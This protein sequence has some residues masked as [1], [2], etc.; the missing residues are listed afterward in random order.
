MPT[1][2]SQVVTNPWMP[3]VATKANASVDT[4][5]L[6]EHAAQ[7]GDHRPAEQAARAAGGHGIGEEAAEHRARGRR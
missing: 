5:E 2:C 4:A 1:F 3:T 6:G 7:R